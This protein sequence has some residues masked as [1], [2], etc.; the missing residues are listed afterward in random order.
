M[1]RI[2]N[3]IPLK[4]SLSILII[5]S[6]ML[7]LIG[8]YYSNRFNAEIDL[9]VSE[10]M[11]LPAALM[12]QRALNFSSV[13]DFSVLSELLNIEVQEAFVLKKDG[14][15]FF[16]ADPEK[17]GKQYLSYLDVKERRQLDR[18]FDHNQQ[19]RFVDPKGHW[20][21]SSLS[22]IRADD[23][24]LGCLYLKINGE[25]VL[26]L[27]RKVMLLF[28]LGALV[29]IILTTVLE[30]LIVYRLVVPRIRNTSQVLRRISDGDF[31]ARI[32]NSGSPDQLGTMMEQVNVM[33]STIEHYTRKLQVLNTAAES[34]ANA[35]SKDEIIQQ[36]TDIIEQQL[37]VRRDDFQIFD[38]SEKARAE[39]EKR[40]TVFTLP[41]IDD[42]SNYQVL[43]FVATEE[44]QELDSVDHDFVKTLSRMVTVAT[45]RMKGFEEVS[46]AE[47]RYR[48]LFTSALEGIFRTTPEGRLLE[49]NPALAAMTGYK[50]VEELLEQMS[51]IGRQMY[52]DPLERD[53]VRF[54]LE[55]EDKIHDREIMLKRKDGMVF[56]A[57]LSAYTVRDENGRLQGFDVRIFNISERKRR[58]QAE[59]DQ[60]AAEAV[61]IA[62]SRLVDDLEWK[63]RQLVEALNELKATQMQ[64]M[65]SE[66]MAA[67]GMTAGGVAHDLNNILSGV[68]SFP[69]LLLTTISS[70]NEMREPLETIL[71]SGRRAAAIVAD[72]LTLT[73][74]AVR[75]KRRVQL[76]AVIDEYLLSVE[77]K[78]LMELHPG[79]E[80]DTSYASAPTLM[81]C[82]PVH[83]QKVVMN[84][85]INA[86]EAIDGVGEVLITT[87]IETFHSGSD[88]S[89][90]DTID[91]LAVMKVNDN[92]PGI[93]AENV[94]HIFEPFY[95]RKVMGM[96]GTGL[97][98]TVVWNVVNEHGGR[99][100]VDTSNEGTE[101]TLY[102]PAEDGGVAQ[103]KEE[104]ST[105]QE[106]S[107]TGRILVVDDEPLQRDIAQKMLTRFGYEV[108]VCSSGEEAVKYLENESVDL[109]VLD[110]LM[111]PGINGLETYRRIL[112]IHPRQKAVIVSGYSEN[113]DVKRAMQLG[114]GA[115]VKKPYTM[116]QIAQSVKK[117]LETDRFPQT[118]NP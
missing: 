73:Q 70:D 76:E 18:T 106:M 96:S 107:G 43:A 68:V 39:R 2:F 16:T 60:L 49:A 38:G 110:M 28:G 48:H 29:T 35:R 75:E 63:N 95:T 36:A 37:P 109:L 94:K 64:L 93:P 88:A 97:G 84:L 52:A 6:I 26:A 5:E 72:L 3:S 19:A 90:E 69:E 85:V 81:Q 27:K 82:S 56:P 32:S 113:K 108:V 10:K 105:G 13:E 12:S 87:G 59:R 77:F 98:L 78:Q 118:N 51:D 8:I 7:T 67:V 116:H 30:A 22:P 20:A 62:K 83:I 57:S 112:E 14:T 50:S 115:F 100:E 74:G 61:S 40:E 89:G 33:I 24:L 101:F 41:V 11:F 66:K 31:S 86:V 1:S 45:D 4:I 104:P 114:A 71:S 117:E 92:G 111:P 15:I 53:E 80:V 17:E 42:D 21:I 79:V 55:T 103:K 99:I 25:E 91:R 58:E 47:I 44:Y 65:Q 46:E 102:F 34:F 9:G 54:Q 23:K